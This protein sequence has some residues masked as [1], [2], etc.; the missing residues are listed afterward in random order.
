[1]VG[2]SSDKCFLMAARMKA[3]RFLATSST[4][5]MMEA[6]KRMLIGI[7]IFIILPTLKE[8]VDGRECP[9]RWRSFHTGFEHECLTAEVCDCWFC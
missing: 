7:I 1:M 4:S 9:E 6:G 8:K 2:A 3:E 5:F